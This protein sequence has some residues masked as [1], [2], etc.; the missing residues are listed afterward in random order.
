MKDTRDTKTKN[1]LT[2]PGATRQAALKAR[3]EA[4]GFKRS[5]VWIKTADYEAGKYAA[6]MG[7]TNASDCPIDR[8]RLSWM[9]G[10]CEHLDK[11]AKSKIDALTR[12]KE[13]A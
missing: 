12:Q 13:G 1:L 2:T 4:E 9:M 3:R 8:H 10:Y 6:E 11:A 5:T 7:S